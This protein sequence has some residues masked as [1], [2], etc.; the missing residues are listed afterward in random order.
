MDDQFDVFKAAHEKDYGPLIDLL[1]SKRE[2]LPY[3]RELL[4]KCGLGRNQIFGMTTNRLMTIFLH[5]PEEVWA[6]AGEQVPNKEAGRG[7]W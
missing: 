6:P 2:L 1:R 4:I 5:E 7:W 3:H